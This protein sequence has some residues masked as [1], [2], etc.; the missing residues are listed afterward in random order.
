MLKG[1]GRATGQALSG[2][3]ILSDV[4]VSAERWT[5]EYLQEISDPTYLQKAGVSIASVADVAA[6]SVCTAVLGRAAF[7]AMWP[8]LVL[9]KAFHL[10]K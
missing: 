1:C 4:K 7:L 3:G 2:D 6:V 9:P 8:L 5:E 10:Q